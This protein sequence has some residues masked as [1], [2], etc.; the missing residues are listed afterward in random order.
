MLL[1]T[2][3]IPRNST[4]ALLSEDVRKATCTAQT[5]VKVLFMMRE[6]FVLM[7]GDMQDLLDGKVKEEEKLLGAEGGTTSGL[8]LTMDDLEVGRT[9]GIGAFGRVKLVKVKTDPNSP[10]YALK[11]QSKKAIVE[12][13]LQDHVMN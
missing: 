13:G 3:H 7:L 12:N 2:P 11:C 8:N 9:L 5:N 6:D 4:Q 1:L 10:T